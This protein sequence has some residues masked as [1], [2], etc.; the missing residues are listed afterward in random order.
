MLAGD[1]W[2]ESFAP[3]WLAAGPAPKS[4]TAKP[5]LM[6]A[7]GAIASYFLFAAGWTLFGIASVRTRVFPLAISIVISL[8]GIA[9]YQARLAR[10][11]IP[12]GVALAALGTWILVTRPAAVGMT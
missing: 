5:S 4:L 8:G 12:H 6:F 9:G 11:G 3:P 7:L 10:W 1:R 2:F